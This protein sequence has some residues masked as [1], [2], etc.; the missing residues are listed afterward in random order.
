MPNAQK[1]R[2]ATQ[3]LKTPSPTILS[4]PLLNEGRERLVSGHFIRP[5]QQLSERNTDW[6]VSKM[7]KRSHCESETI[8]PVASKSGTEPINRQRAQPSIVVWQSQ[9]AKSHSTSQWS[10]K[11]QQYNKFYMNDINNTNHYTGA[12]NGN[13]LY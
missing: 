4:V 3:T 8:N 9:A 2:A 7:D 1:I 12:R 13:E 10:S 5:N 11:L 6:S